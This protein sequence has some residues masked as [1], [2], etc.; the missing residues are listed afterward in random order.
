MSYVCG[1]R[2]CRLSVVGVGLST[3]CLLTCCRPRVLSTLCLLNVLPALGLKHFM[4]T[5]ILS[6]KFLMFTL[7]HRPWAL[8][9]LCFLSSCHCKFV[10]VSPALGL[11]HL[12]S[13]T[14]YRPRALSTLCHLRITGLDL[15][16]FMFA[17][18]LPALGLTHH[19]FSYVLSASGYKLSDESAEISKHEQVYIAGLVPAAFR[20]HTYLI[21]LSLRL[22]T[23]R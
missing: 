6:I 2:C 9:I 18:N 15:K 10:Y 22:Y 11:K 3:L 17:F 5:L 7:C 21:G 20:Q 1:R 4:F 14:Y 23:S 16:F 13:L 12:C 8:I 19:M